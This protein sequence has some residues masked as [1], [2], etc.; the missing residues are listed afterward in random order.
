[1]ADDNTICGEVWKTIED[2]PDYEV[3]SLGEVRSRSRYVCF[4][5]RGEKVYRW[6]SGKILK[7][8]YSKG[9][10][11]VSLNGKT[12]KVPTLVCTAFHGPKPSGSHQVAHYD[13]NPDNNRWRNVRW[14]TPMENHEDSVRHGTFRLADFWG[15]NQPPEPAR[16]EAHRC[17]KLRAPE[18]LEIRRMKSDGAHPKDIAKV[19]G[20][21]LTTVHNIVS[22]HTWKHV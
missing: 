16:G 9:Y 12:I 17:A 7:P 8:K 1:L 14:A 21:N 4:L 11:V 5:A 18:V 13:G 15:E 3:S 20:V 10:P 22:R 2:H 6:W 19:F